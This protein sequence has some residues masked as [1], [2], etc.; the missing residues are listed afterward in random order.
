M[1]KCMRLTSL[2]LDVSDEF[3]ATIKSLTW[4]APA[5]EEVCTKLAVI[6]MHNVT[7]RRADLYTK[8]LEDGQGD[9]KIV[10]TEVPQTNAIN[11]AQ[12]GKLLLDRMSI[13]GCLPN[14]P[15]KQ[16]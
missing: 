4:T 1:F 14:A 5:S 8:D 3:E 11:R 13:V 10:L 12:R 2:D 9:N 6:L 7:H 16:C 15:E